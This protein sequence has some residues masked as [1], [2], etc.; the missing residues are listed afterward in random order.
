MNADKREGLTVSQSLSF[1]VKITLEGGAPRR[2]IDIVVADSGLAGARPSIGITIP[3]G[4]SSATP[5]TL[6]SEILNKII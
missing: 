5:I 3:G 2:R 6:Y 1:L 4:R